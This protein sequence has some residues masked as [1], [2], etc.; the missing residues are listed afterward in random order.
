MQGIELVQKDAMNGLMLCL[1]HDL[2][3]VLI[4]TK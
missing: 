4:K 3:Y 1:W 2:G